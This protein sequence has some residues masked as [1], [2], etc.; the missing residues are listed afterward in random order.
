MEDRKEPGGNLHEGGLKWPGGKPQGLQQA[1]QVYKWWGVEC[2]QIFGTVR[3]GRSLQ[4]PA[5]ANHQN[6]GF[7]RCPLVAV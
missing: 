5:H 7:A 4:I 6:A 1:C 3:G 2:Q